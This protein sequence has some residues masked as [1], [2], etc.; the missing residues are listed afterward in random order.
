M[1]LGA[2]RLRRQLLLAAVV[3]VTAAASGCGR[4]RPS[5]PSPPPATPPPL[6][7]R[8]VWHLGLSPSGEWLTFESMLQRGSEVVWSVS[9]LMPATGGPARPL[10]P[11]MMGSSFP[12]WSP[13]AEEVAYVQVGQTT[14]VHVQG[15]EEPLPRLSVEFEELW[16]AQLA[17]SPDGKTLAGLATDYQARRRDPVLIDVAT[18]QRR[19]AR[20]RVPASVSPLAFVDGGEALL[21]AREG[22]PAEPGREPRLFLM[23]ASTTT[24]EMS[25]Y[26]QLE[27]TLCQVAVP[28]DGGL[29]LQLLHHRAGTEADSPAAHEKELVLLGSDGQSL[30]P[31]R[32]GS[33]GS[34]QSLRRRQGQWELVFERGGDL[35][36]GPL[37]PEGEGTLLR[38]TQTPEAEIGAIF[39]PD[40]E[41]V[42]F[43]RSASLQ[44]SPTLV[45]RRNLADGQETV[46][47]A[48]TAEM[49]KQAPSP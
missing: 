33:F 48:V 22:Q 29:L 40:G 38:V 30:Q 3:A 15:A 41:A 43:V 5:R 26:A 11:V 45:V 46:L 4:G 37:K 16:L 19:L 44:A 35:F 14:S 18:G 2:A 12:V 9:W 20:L 13:R 24:T 27:A 7:V 49:V 36:V 23:K 32:E 6:R 34:A 10:A 42:Y 25:E 47:A 17:W 1:T 8:L 28:V 31:L 21:F 39:S